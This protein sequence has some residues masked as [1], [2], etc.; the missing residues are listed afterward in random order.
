MTTLPFTEFDFMQKYRE[1]FLAHSNTIEYFELHQSVGDSSLCPN[2][3]KNEFSPAENWKFKQ[4]VYVEQKNH[5]LRHFSP[6]KFLQLTEYP[7]IEDHKNTLLDNEN[8]ETGRLYMQLSHHLLPEHPN[9]Y[10]EKAFLKL[11]TALRIMNA[12]NFSLALE[13]VDRLG[14]ILYSYTIKSTTNNI[15]IWDKK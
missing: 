10:L 14:Y 7:Y 3:P 11:F 1:M 4:S 8:E 13:N 12:S 9:F 15:R 6:W 5:I 2:Q